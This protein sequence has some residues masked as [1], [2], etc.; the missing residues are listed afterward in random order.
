ME[1][2]P[3]RG[4]ALLAGAEEELQLAIDE[5]RELAHG[6]HPSGLTTF[7]LAK[8]IPM[9]AARS[10]V[11]VEVV[12]VAVATVRRRDRSCRVLRHRRGDRQRAEVRAGVGMRVRC[13]VVRDVIEV[14]VVDDGIG[15]ASESVGS[16]LEGLRD[17]IEAIGGGFEVESP[18]GRGT[19][20]AATIP[21]TAGV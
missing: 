13:A 17:R 18:P 20:I 7:G 14:E 9:V 19:R 21:A 15:G 11:P 12:E 6:I 10:T 4:A 8:A 5:L 3:K 2:A 16:G 1:R